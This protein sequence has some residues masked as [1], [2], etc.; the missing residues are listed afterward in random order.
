MVFDH[1]RSATLSSSTANSADDSTISAEVAYTSVFPVRAL[2]NPSQC[3]GFDASDH[4][5]SQSAKSKHP[6]HL[7]GN[8]PQ[9]MPPTT[10]YRMSHISLFN[11][12][13]FFSSRGQNWIEHQTGEKFDLEQYFVV[14]PP[15]QAQRSS[16]SSGCNLYPADYQNLDLPEK[17]MVHK[18]L[19]WYRSA[20][21]LV[22]PFVVHPTLF[23]TTIAVAYENEPSCLFPNRGVAQASIFAFFALSKEMDQDS[24][25]N[26]YKSKSSEYASK[27][28]AFLPQILS[29]PATLDGLQ[30][31]LM[32][33]A[34]YQL[35][36]GNIHVVETLL[37]S[38]S[39]FL[40]RLEGHL[41]P[42]LRERTP[43]PVEIQIR[44]IFWICYLMEKEL[45]LRIGSSPLLAYNHC[46][47][48]IPNGLH[49]SQ[50]ASLSYPEICFFA[51]AQLSVIQGRIYD[52]LYSPLAHQLPEA[53]ILR[54]IRALDEQLE[55]WRLSLP[56][57]IRP[58]ISTTLAME[59][60]KLKEYS[61]LFQIQWHYWM[62]MIH[63]SSSRCVRWMGEKPANIQGHNSSLMI[64]VHFAR[65][66]LQKFF[67]AQLYVQKKNFRFAI[68]YVCS[69]VITLFSSIVICP[70]SPESAAD[71]ML[72][73]QA[74]NCI[75][76]HAEWRESRPNAANIDIIK[77]FMQNLV[78]VAISAVSRTNFG[79]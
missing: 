39:R 23:E 45:C 32:L 2:V 65:S 69:A 70:I 1:Y 40:F 58:T 15:W 30:V 74:V 48:A 38:A 56:V 77:P 8:E 33:S 62:I 25:Q 71:I 37:S 7:A 49:F 50:L 78:Q 4:G 73:E 11:G 64:T 14:G 26:G 42:F 54:S 5:T 27:A 6:D 53:D 18:L 22:F 68:F 47:L 29:A 52:Q 24:Y 60:L 51:M 31:L 20:Y 16:S 59:D 66:L 55:E 75:E 67:D 36:S 41:D 46:D 13:P 43:S 28:V 35:S 79:M 17:A 44:N 61:M 76:S 34:Y 21:V 57:A 63:Q 9:H 10:R 72:I 3:D 19:Q 12:L